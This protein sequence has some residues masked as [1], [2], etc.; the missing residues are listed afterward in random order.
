[1]YRSVKN[2]PLIDVGVKALSPT[3]F[4]NEKTVESLT[5]SR[6]HFGAAARVVQNVILDA[7]A[8]ALNGL[9]NLGVCET[10]YLLSRSLIKVSTTAGSAK[11][12]VSPK[13]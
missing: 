8:K 12:E 5:A 10:H 4:F 11:V 9:D 2:L 3:G 6:T 7:C 1:M 13:S